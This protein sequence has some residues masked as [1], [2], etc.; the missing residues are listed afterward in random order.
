MEFTLWFGCL[1]IWRGRQELV[2][3]DF[4]PS[5]LR[6]RRRANDYLVVQDN[7]QEGIVEVDL[8]VVSN[9]AQFSEFVHEKIDP[10]PRCANHFRQHLLRYFGKHLLR[11]ARRSIAR[12][13]QQS[14]RQPF[15]AGVKE[16]ID[17]I[18]FDSEIS[19]QRVSDEA[20]GEFVFRVERANHLVFHNDENGGGSGRCCVASWCCPCPRDSGS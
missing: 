2:P 13:Q 19:H 9:D 8:A 12:E 6:I 17:Q 1:R 14:A 4:S 5:F 20:V 3:C 18:F 7:A 15:F 11:I 10:R 16:P